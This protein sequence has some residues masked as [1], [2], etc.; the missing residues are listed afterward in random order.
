[1]SH[2]DGGGRQVSAKTQHGWVE[3]K[4][5]KKNPVWVDISSVLI[6]EFTASSD[7]F[8]TGLQTEGKL[9]C[10]FDP[11]TTQ[12]FVSVLHHLTAEFFSNTF[13]PKS[14]EEK[15]R[16]VRFD[17]AELLSRTK[18]TVA[19]LTCYCFNIMTYDLTLRHITG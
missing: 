8:I 18:N 16:E 7:R 4:K 5:K 6:L 2:D 12:T 11:S 3:G 15:R 17:Q 1:M 13:R 10:S 19:G 9:C 14:S